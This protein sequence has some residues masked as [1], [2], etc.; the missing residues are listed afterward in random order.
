MQLRKESLPLLPKEST[1]QAATE[2]PRGV[3]PPCQPAAH[4]E[5]KTAVPTG[6]HHNSHQR[7]DQEGLTPHCPHPEPARQVTS[8]AATHS[9]SRTLSELAIHQADRALANP[10]LL[11]PGHL[12]AWRRDTQTR[13]L[14]SKPTH[15]IRADTSTS[16]AVPSTVTQSRCQPCNPSEDEKGASQGSTHA[17]RARCREGA[18]LDKLPMQ[19]SRSPRTRRHPSQRGSAEVGCYTVRATA[20]APHN[21]GKFS[22]N[23][24]GRTAHRVQTRNASPTACMARSEP[25]DTG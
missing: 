8:S 10:M 14:S 17:R 6:I 7:R 4:P 2:C 19:H 15:P 25:K 11:L 23:E 16:R 13:D 9:P 20:N 21:P 5:S 22:A 18:L 1:Q 3:H 12:P 24:A